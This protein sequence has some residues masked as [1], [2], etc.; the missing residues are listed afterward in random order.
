MRGG[1]SDG[2]IADRILKVVAHKPER[3]Y[4]AEGQM[5]AGRTMNQIGG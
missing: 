4:L 1:A 5:V 3:H 2:E